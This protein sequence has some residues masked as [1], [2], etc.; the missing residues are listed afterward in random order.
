[1][2]VGLQVCMIQY[3]A[4]SIMSCQSLLSGCWSFLAIVLQASKPQN[5]GYMQHWKRNFMATCA[6]R[7]TCKTPWNVMIVMG[8]GALQF[9][10]W[11]FRFHMFSH[12]TM[13]LDTKSFIIHG[14]GQDDRNLGPPALQVVSVD[15]SPCRK[16]SESVS[17]SQGHLTPT[18]PTTP[19]SPVQAAD[20]GIVLSLGRIEMISFYEPMI[21]NHPRLDESGWYLDDIWIDH[22][23]PVML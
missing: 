3:V 16:M 4:C 15:P 7:G 19:T 5:S 9:W 21:E 2:Q 8:I 17:S 20:L 18:T 14:I 23:M 11:C 10:L 12:Y 13:L 6:F 1:M 22:A